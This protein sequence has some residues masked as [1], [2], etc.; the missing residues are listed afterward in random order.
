VVLVWASVVLV[1]GVVVLLPE[2]SSALV[3]GLVEAS[4]PSLEVALA[5]PAAVDPEELSPAYSTP[6]EVAPL[7]RGEL[8]LAEASVLVTAA[9]K[10]DSTELATFS[11]PVTAVA[12]FGLLLVLG[13]ELFGISVLNSLL[14]VSSGLFVVLVCEAESAELA[15][16][17]NL[18]SS[19]G[20]LLLFW[21]V[22]LV[23]GKLGLEVG[24][25]GA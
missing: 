7:S 10:S 4:P 19:L 25:F 13:G 12:S 22:E 20:G 5:A 18:G 9:A 21:F 15:A 14:V 23:A 17:A 6:T 16:D 11:L 2:L 24:E 1:G 8:E 3:V